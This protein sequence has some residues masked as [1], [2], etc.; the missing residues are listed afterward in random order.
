MTCSFFDT[1]N[2]APECHVSLAAAVK[3]TTS[4]EL[5]TGV[6]KP[7]DAARRGHCIGLFHVAGH[8]Q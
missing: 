3:E 6:T 2:L 5:G 8:Q 1:Q 4:L 7:H